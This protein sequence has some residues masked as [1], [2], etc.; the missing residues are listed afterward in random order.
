MAH[1]HHSGH[2]HVH[3]KQGRKTCCSSHAALAQP[4]HTAADTGDSTGA[5]VGCAAACSEKH[6]DGGGS[7]AGEDPEDPE[8][9]EEREDGDGGGSPSCGISSRDGADEGA[10]GCGCEDSAAAQGWRLYLPVAL[11]LTLLLSGLALEKWVK[12]DFFSGTAALLWYAAAYLP[13]GLPVLRSAWQSVRQGSLFT[14]FFLMSVATVGAFAIGEH[15]EGVAV[16]LFYAV[17][18]L[19]QARAVQRAR[20]N[21]QALLD[22]RPNIAYV[23]RGSDFV[24][25]HPETVRTGEIIQVKVGE[26]IPLDGRLLSEKASLNTAALTGE[27]RPQHVSSGKTVMAG[28]INLQGVIDIAVEK[29]FHDSSISRILELVENATSR[30][31]ETELLIRRLAKIYTPVVTYLAI[32]IVL[33][34]YFIVSDYVFSQW[35]YRALVFLVISCPCALVVSIPLGYFGGLGAASKNGLLFK[36]A[37]FLDRMTEIT[38]VV[39]D[40]TGTLT[41]GVFRIQRIVVHN[42]L[43][44]SD[45]MQ[46]LMSVEAKSTHPIARAIMAYAG[47]RPLL[48]VKDIRE[49]AGKGLTASV[50]QKTVRAGNQALLKAAGISVPDNVHDIVESVVL[51]AIDDVFAGYVV[52][53]DELKADARDS[54]SRLRQAGIQQI[55]MLS[56]DKNS[57]TQQLAADLK[58]DDAR[59]ELLP[60]DKLRVVED[61]M[62]SQSSHVAFVG[63]GIN[64]APVLAAADVGIA[65]GGLGS[66]VAIETADVVIQTDQPSRIATAIAIGKSTRRIIWQNIALAFGIKALVLLLGAVGMASMWQA[67]F[68]DVGVAL[69]AIGNAVRLQKMW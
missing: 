48:P 63:D 34:P 64:D 30:K 24:R 68:A 61:L 58:L 17:G 5:A 39:M 40:K 25:V 66:D 18:E 21:I 29:T 32:T 26:K 53:A 33:L 51:V 16:M 20:S 69:L 9:S 35:L 1:T 44:E 67:V 3:D 52:I 37:T 49:I 22:V 23:Q 46:I 42:N 55:I 12:A 45:F 36:G 65:M 43:S 57:I 13:V 10:A 15:P 62:R 14:E 60:E 4:A 8:D 2:R 56:G 31:S 28:S 54:I 47:D 19:F 11:S 7:A 59:G 50:Q 6:D 38:T 41:Q 27:S